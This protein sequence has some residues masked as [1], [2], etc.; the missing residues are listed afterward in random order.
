MVNR[1]CLDVGI[2]LKNPSVGLPDPNLKRKTVKKRKLPLVY[3]FLI[4]TTFC[5]IKYWVMH[6]FQKFATSNFCD[7]IKE[8]SHYGGVY[9]VG[10]PGRNLKRK[11]VKIQPVLP[12]N[13]FF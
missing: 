12:F 13:L 4:L 7:Q 8:R 10:L 5:F 11:T 1:A 6:S 3:R 2:P 9:S